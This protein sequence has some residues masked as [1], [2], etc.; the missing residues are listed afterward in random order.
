[1]AKE[2]RDIGNDRRSSNIGRYGSN[3]AGK[4]KKKRNIETLFFFLI[5][6]LSNLNFIVKRSSNKIDSTSGVIN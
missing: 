1:M 4:N 3:V 5:R 6:T 2:A